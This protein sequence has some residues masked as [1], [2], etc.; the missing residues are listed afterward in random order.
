MASVAGGTDLGALSRTS[1]LSFHWAGTGVSCLV[2]AAALSGPF[3]LA[4]DMTHHSKLIFPWEVKD[5]TPRKAVDVV[6]RSVV[7]HR[8]P[9]DSV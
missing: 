3:L 1:D 4:S 6:K 9:I 8:S 5:L 2:R 7:V